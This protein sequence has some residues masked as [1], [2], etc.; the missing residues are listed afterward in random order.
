MTKPAHLWVTT[1]ATARVLMP[2]DPVGGGA[3]PPV[4]P[5]RHSRAV[6]AAE[7][8]GPWLVR[9]AV[10]IPI[11]PGVVTS[12][13]QRGRWMGALHVRWLRYMGIAPATLYE[14]PPVAH[15]AS[16]GMRLQGDVLVGP[17][18][19]TSVAEVRRPDHALVVA[20]TL[21]HPPPWELLCR[22]MGM[23]MHEAGVLDSLSVCASSMLARS[24][25]AQLWA[26]SLRRMLHLSLSFSELQQE[27]LGGE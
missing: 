13:L 26:A 25:D 24:V 18:K 7:L 21:L 14:G 11:A 4:M 27:A 15:W 20:S 8:A 3:P 17:Q 1:A 5:L 16:F 10:R 6:Q 9:A 19:I 23:P 12:A 22:A 2:G